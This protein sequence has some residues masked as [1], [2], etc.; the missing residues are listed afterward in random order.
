VELDTSAG[1]VSVKIDKE[2]KPFQ[3]D[4]CYDEKYNICFEITNFQGTSKN[5][6]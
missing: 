6:L 5:Y 4:A 1:L 2:V 3:F